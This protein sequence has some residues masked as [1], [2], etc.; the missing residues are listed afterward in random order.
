MGVVSPSIVLR[1]LRRAKSHCHLCFGSYSR[2]TL[3]IDFAQSCLESSFL[4][5]RK[6]SMQ[7]KMVIAFGAISDYMVD[8]LKTS[9]TSSQ[10][11]WR[12]TTDMCPGAVLLMEH[13]TLLLLANSGRF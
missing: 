9:Q 8:A 3:V 10:G 2:K 5:L 4:S 11:F 13:N 7:E 1:E 12:V 6:F